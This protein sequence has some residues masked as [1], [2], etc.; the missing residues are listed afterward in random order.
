M[1]KKIC[2]PVGTEI[3]VVY[4]AFFF[5]NSSLYREDSADQSQSANSKVQ[6]ERQVGAEL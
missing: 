3:I 2:S 1:E 6:R 4:V 5:F